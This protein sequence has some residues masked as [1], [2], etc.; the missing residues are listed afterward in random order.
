MHLFCNE[1]GSLHQRLCKG[2]IPLTL[3]SLWRG[4]D[5]A[6]SWCLFFAYF[7]I[8]ILHSIFSLLTDVFLGWMLLTAA[9]MHSVFGLLYSV[10]PSKHTYFIANN[11]QWHLHIG[12]INIGQHPRKLLHYDHDDNIRNDENIDAN[13]LQNADQNAYNSIGIV[14]TRCTLYFYLIRIQKTAPK[15][16][17][18]G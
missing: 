1:E 9:C 11:K 7:F 2:I 14:K 17:T 4:G 6:L 12:D 18:H 10:N 8:L 5:F 16:V 3:E 13:L 15:V